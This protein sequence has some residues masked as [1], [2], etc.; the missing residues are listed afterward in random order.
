MYHG[1]ILKEWGENPV[2]SHMESAIKDWVLVTLIQGAYL[3]EYHLWEKACKAYFI[4][5]GERNGATIDLRPRRHQP[6]PQMVRTAVEGFEVT[7]PPETFDAIET[8]RN[9]VNVMKHEDG[10]TN[11]HFISLADYE[12][13]VSAIE[14]FWESLADQEHVHP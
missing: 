7:I 2:L 3:R 8:M 5:M 9:C 11:D 4:S 13:A 6:F 12:A 1:A 14:G 10:L